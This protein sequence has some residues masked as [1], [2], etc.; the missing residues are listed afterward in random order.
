MLALTWTEYKRHSCSEI[1]TLIHS[2]F[3]EKCFF[4]SLE[5]YTVHWLSRIKSMLWPDSFSNVCMIYRP[6]RTAPK[7]QAR[8]GSRLLVRYYTQRYQRGH[9]SQRACGEPGFVIVNALLLL[10]R[11]PPP[12][13][14]RG[15]PKA[16]TSLWAPAM[17]VR[18]GT[19]LKA[20]CR[21]Q[22]QERTQN[23]GQRAQ[24]GG[25]NGGQRAQN[26]LQRCLT[27]VEKNIYI[28]QHQITFSGLNTSALMLVISGT[29]FVH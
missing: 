24:N 17:S 13:P 7:R 16:I 28:D 14:L 23:G 2:N 12:F 11:L 9:Q 20:R 18:W 21:Y 5:I 10:M 26:G 6:F 27:D 22:E 4:S 3:K 1:I 8:Y 25:Q 29:T 19:D 15:I